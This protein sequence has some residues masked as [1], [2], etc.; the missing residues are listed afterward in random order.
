MKTI[1]Q[2]ATLIVFVAASAF[3]FSGPSGFEVGDK[4]IDF[5]LKNVDGK[6]VSLSDYPDA[7]G[8]VVI[9]T[10]NECPFAKKYEDR[11]IDLHNKYASKGYP[12]IAIN[13]NDPEIQP[14]DNFEKM[15]QRVKEK[16][17]PYPYLVDEGQKIFPAYGATRTPHV[18]LL[19]DEMVVQYIGAIDDNVDDGDAASHKYVEEAISAMEKGEKVDPSETK[20]IGCS[21]KAKNA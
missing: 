8:Y 5:K 11:I 9:F 6:Y 12:V 2:F 10:C 7:K 21:I 14:G 19:D 1:I 13:P 4:A 16:S 17:I 18:F 3:T 15:K 20:A